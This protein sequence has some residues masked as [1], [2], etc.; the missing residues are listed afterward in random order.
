MNLITMHCYPVFCHNPSSVQI[1]CS[2]VG[3]GGSRNSSDSRCSSRGSVT[4]NGS[5]ITAS[6]QLQLS[7]QALKIHKNLTTIMVM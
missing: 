1:C 5:I 2:G 3:G 4:S 7:R 6:E